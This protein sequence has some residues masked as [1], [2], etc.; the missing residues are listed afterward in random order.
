MSIGK[1]QL[2]ALAAA[3]EEEELLLGLLLRN[4]DEKRCGSGSPVGMDMVFS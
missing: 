2:S 3:G 1:F 4:V